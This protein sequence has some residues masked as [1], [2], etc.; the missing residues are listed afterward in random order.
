MSLMYYSIIPL[1]KV[2]WRL[3]PIMA[4]TKTEV[5]GV[6]RAAEFAPG[7]GKNLEE[8]LGQDVVVPVKPTIDERPYNGETRKIVMITTEDGELYH[9]W[10]DS[11]AEKIEQIPEVEFPLAFRFVRLK[12]RTPGFTVYSFE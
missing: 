10:S 7:I 1:Q 4:T 6:R 12:T 11:L 3:V 9:A 8:I 2:N 5:T